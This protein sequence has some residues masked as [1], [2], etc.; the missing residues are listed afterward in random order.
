MARRS[1]YYIERYHT[2]ALV[3]LLVKHKS[4]D[5]DLLRRFVTSPNM[6]DYLGGRVEVERL[7]KRVRSMCIAIAGLGNF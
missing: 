6:T 2:V 4:C 7:L 1:L 3:N 5:P